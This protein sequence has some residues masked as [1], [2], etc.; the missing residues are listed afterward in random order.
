[1]FEITLI[2]I[3]YVLSVMTVFLCIVGDVNHCQ[4]AETRLFNYTY[5]RILLESPLFCHSEEGEAGE[6]TQWSQM[7]GVTGRLQTLGWFP[8]RRP[9]PV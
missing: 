5:S 4:R 2:V 9:P 3:M 6:L 1:M 7:G 8:L